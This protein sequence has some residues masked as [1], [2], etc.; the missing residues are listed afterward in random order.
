MHYDGALV[1]KN[2]LKLIEEKGQKI[3]DFESDMTVS[4][5]YIS[6]TFKDGAKPNINFLINVAKY[7][8][9]GLDTLLFRDLSL[10]SSDEQKKYSFLRKLIKDTWDSEL[11]WEP[12]TRGYLS[13]R[14]EENPDGSPAHPLFEMTEYWEDNCRHIRPT[15]ISRA[16][17]TDTY[18]NDDCYH[19]IMKTGATLYIMNV[20]QCSYEFDPTPSPDPVKEAWM[21]LKDGTKHFLFD[22]NAKNHIGESL[23]E[24]YSVIKRAANCPKS[25]QAVDDAIDAYLNDIPFEI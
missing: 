3:G 15:F 18:I 13:S 17:E 14:L 1:Y 20:G 8:E 10:P 19:L 6:R 21:L 7:F 9:I 12:E 25:S 16:F 5:G 22:S 24:L 11:H 4:T 2:I 23:C